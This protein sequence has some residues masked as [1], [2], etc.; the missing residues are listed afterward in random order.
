MFRRH[1]RRCYLRVV[2]HMQDTSAIKVEVLSMGEQHTEYRPSLSDTYRV[3]TYERG[4]LHAGC[5]EES[6]DGLLQLTLGNTADS[7]SMPV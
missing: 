4:L 7:T 5:S 1:S 6:A 3:I 2:P